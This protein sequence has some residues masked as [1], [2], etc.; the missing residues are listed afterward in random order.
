MH[1][2]HHNYVDQR[3][4]EWRAQST[5]RR[6]EDIVLN[7]QAANESMSEPNFW[8]DIEP[9]K[10]RP[11]W[12]GVASDLCLGLAIIAAVIALCLAPIWRGLVEIVRG[13]V[14]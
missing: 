6:D 4:A 5:S 11:R 1:T 14:K 9:S 10:P 2:S 13:V 12:L 3:H 7:R 8:L